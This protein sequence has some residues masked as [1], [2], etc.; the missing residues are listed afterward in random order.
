[1]N[2]N[3]EFIDEL[4]RRGVYLE[5]VGVSSYNPNEF[6]KV[7]LQYPFYFDFYRHFRVKNNLK[8][9]DI[10]RTFLMEKS[11]IVLVGN[12]VNK[13]FRDAVLKKCK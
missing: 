6:D 3:K 13:S 2:D 4:R 12:W 9:I 10:T 8:F 5:L 11:E 7:L 1:M